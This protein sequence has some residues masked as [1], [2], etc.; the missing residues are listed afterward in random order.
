MKPN[1]IIIILLILFTQVLFVGRALSKEAE[2]IFVDIESASPSDPEEIKLACDL[3]GVKLR[4]H[5]VRTIN[6]A[7]IQRASKELY[8]KEV[9]ILTAR[10]L[11][12]FNE[13]IISLFGQS[14]MKTKI[15]ILDINSDTDIEGLKIWSENQIKNFKQ[16]V[17][18]NLPSSIRVVKNDQISKELGELEYPLINEGARKI[19]GFELEDSAG[20]MSLV[21]VVDES[22]KPVCPV[23]LKTDSMKRSVF[24]LS[25]WEKVFRAETSTFLRILPILM[26]LKYSFGDRCWHGSND[27]AN[28][29]ID[30]P[31]LREPYG[32]LSFADLC[33]EAKKNSFHVTIGFIPYNYQKSHNDAIEIFQ[34]C[35]Q[36]LSM[37]LHGNNHDLSEFRFSGNERVTDRKASDVQPDEKS[38]L[39]ALYRMDAFKQKTGLSYDRVMIFPRGAF[40]KESLGLLK[41][42]NFLMTVNSTRPTN[43]ADVKN[44]VD[45][46]RGITLEY[47]NFAMVRRHGIPDWKNDK[48]A[49][50]ETKRWIKMRLFLDLPV[51]LYT[52]HDFFKD[53]ADSF[54]SIAGTINTIQPD[55][56]WTSLGNIAKS[57][58]L[59]KRVDNRKVEILA[60]TSDLVI[61]N[62]YPVTMKYVVKKQE[63]FVIPIQSVEVDGVNYEYFQDGNHI[64]IEVEVEPGCEKGIR[65]LYYPDY[66]VGSFT[67]SDRDLQVTLIRTLSDFR[68]LY[69]SKLPFGDEIVKVFYSVGGVKNTKIY[70]LGLAGL[71]FILLIWYVKN[72]NSKKRNLMK[73]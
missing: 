72:A 48:P 63:D 60:Y 56:V 6:D 69:L 9:L 68:D 41:K 22:G 31:W 2:V 54:N 34:Q 59:Q 58:Y 32:Y 14:D 67:Y 61:R 5:F 65:I 40:N 45:R 20:A 16:F 44:D 27:Y 12:Y 36:N 66:Q 70:L 53:G 30:D 26:F 35:Q 37:A 47:G 25:S 17:L 51:L 8:D 50:A 1:K 33:R 73:D 43:A 62:K 49:M 52:H 10:V 18:P 13:D 46:L 21:E 64:S 71:I 3:L 57:M 29:T 28:L 55:V 38:I 4:T 19:N 11:K 42:H 24:F 23:F 15:L 7:E 39:Q